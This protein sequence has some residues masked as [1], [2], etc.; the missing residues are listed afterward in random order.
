MNAAAPTGFALA[1]I[2]LMASGAMSGVR[3]QT[4]PNVDRDWFVAPEPTILDYQAEREGEAIKSQTYRSSPI[5][6][7]QNWSLD[8][9]RFPPGTD[10]DPVDLRERLDELQQG[11]AGLRLRVPLRGNR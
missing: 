11:Y 7:N 2:S 8:V 9:G 4:A 1:I 6:R 10:D 5:G 3:A